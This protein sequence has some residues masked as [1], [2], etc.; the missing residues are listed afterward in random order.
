[1][2]V[3]MWSRWEMWRR[4]TMWDAAGD[5]EVRDAVGG[6]RVYV[7]EAGEIGAR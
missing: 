5:S 6:E 7:Q 3:V 1:M 2:R 4:L